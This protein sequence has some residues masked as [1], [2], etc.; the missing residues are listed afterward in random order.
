MMKETYLIIAYMAIW[1]GLSGYLAVLAQ[2]QRKLALRLE[3]L[4][5]QRNRKED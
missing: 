4:D 5:K 1:I 3:L 2:K